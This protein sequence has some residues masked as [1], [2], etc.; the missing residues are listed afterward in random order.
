MVEQEAPTMTPIQ[1]T[2]QYIKDLSFE[3]PNAPQIFN[4]L[5]EAPKIDVNVNVEARKLAES[6]YEVSLT[7]KGEARQKDGDAVFI[8]EL[9]YA[10]VAVLGEVP[11][12]AVRPVLLVEVPRIIFPF[13]RNI[14]ADVTRDGGFPPLMINPVDFFA[15]YKQ[16]LEEEQAASA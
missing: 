13:A 14:M 16:G 15:L 6:T 11:E 8:G 10:A 3:N 9:T 2:G 12:D 4:S 7:V 5:K 1:I